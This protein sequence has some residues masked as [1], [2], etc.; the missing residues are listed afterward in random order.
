MASLTPKI[1]NGH[2]YYYARII[3]EFKIEH[4]FGEMK[5]PHFL[6]WN[7]RLHWTDQKIRVHA[8]CCVAPIKSSVSS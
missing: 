1:V 4:A 8:F 5:N 6:G 2:K 7:P 3:D